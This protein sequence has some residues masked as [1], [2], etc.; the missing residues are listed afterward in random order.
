MRIAF[1]TD[2]HVGTETQ[3]PLGVE[4]R[5]N[6]A[7]ALRFVTD[8]QPDC[9][10][11]GGDICYQTGDRAI[12]RWVQPQLA[13]VSVPVYAISGNH[14]DSVLLAEELGFREDLH[15]N[16]LFFARP[17]EALPAL[18][19]DTSKGYCSEA[20]WTWLKEQVSLVKGDLLVFMHHPPLLAGV[21]HMDANYAFQQRREMMALLHSVPGQVTVVCGHYHVEKVVRSRNV[22]VLITPS[23]FFQMKHDPVEVEIDHYRIGIRELNFSGEQQTSTVHYLEG[24]RAA[25]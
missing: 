18:F 25:V 5:K 6:L 17:L 7:D 4:V 23:L 11:I 8:L 3:K 21:G 1:L 22:T 9:L 19:L 15:G 12:Y 16:E 14:D 13:E 10:V 2:L 24:N 20:Q